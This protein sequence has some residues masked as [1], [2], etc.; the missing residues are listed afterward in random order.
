MRRKLYIFGAQN[1]AEMCHYFFTEDSAY[2]VAGFTV[3]AAYLGETSFCGLPVI[4]YEELR[5]T[6]SPSDADIFV[7]IGVAKINTVR[8][9]RV[10]QVQADGFTLA[11][12][13]S[14]RAHVHRDLVV[15]PNTMVM[16]H[17]MIHPG[18]TIG[19]DTV[20]WSNCGVALKVRIGDHVWIT[21][22]VIGDSATIGDCS[23]IGLNATIAPF[24]NV[25]SHNLIGAAAVITRDT[26]D[27]QVYRGPRS[28][29]SSVSS[30]R[31]RNIPLIR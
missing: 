20:L 9:Q 12:F 15:R 14:S 11:S 18:V 16:D 7:A 4:A 5:K 27:Y 1:F 2:E 30:L 3:D 13:V 25:G 8:A 22:A 28:K 26:L 24:V 10:A 21:S 6:L 23:F 29:P 19:Y 17:V 31:I